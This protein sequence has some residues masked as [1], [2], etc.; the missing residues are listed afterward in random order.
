M[1]HE[2]FYE[3]IFNR[4]FF[5]KLG[6]ILVNLIVIDHCNLFVYNFIKKTLTK[7]YII[8]VL[9]HIKNTNDHNIIT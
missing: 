3:Y 2:I 8:I 6:H 1:S 5:S 9:A 4:Y 7:S